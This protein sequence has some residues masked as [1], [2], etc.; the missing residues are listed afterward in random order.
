[1]TVLPVFTC[2]MNLRDQTRQAFVSSFSSISLPHEQVCSQTPN[3]Q[4]SQYEPKTVFWVLFVSRL[5]TILLL[6]HFP[7]LW[8]DGHPCMV[9]WLCIIVASFY[10]KVRDI[11]PHISLRDLPCRKT[12]K[13][14][15]LHQVSVKLWSVVFP[16]PQQKILASNTTLQFVT[17]ALLIVH[18]LWV[19]TQIYGVEEWGWFFQINVFHQNTPSRFHVFCFACHFD[20]FHIHRQE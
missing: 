14:W 4:V 15:L 12:K 16:G 13:I 5:L 11:F 20:I 8:I 1:M 17:M 7:P 19:K 3:F 9:L 10:S 6:T 18:S 2:M